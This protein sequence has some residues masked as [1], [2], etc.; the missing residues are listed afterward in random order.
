MRKRTYI[1][2]ALMIIGLLLIGIGIA[3]LI[4]LFSSHESAITPELTIASFEKEVKGELSS[5][6]NLFVDGCW[7]EGNKVRCNGTVYG[8]GEE[9]TISEAEVCMFI[10]ENDGNSVNV[11]VV[12]YG[13]ILFLPKETIDSD[14]MQIPTLGIDVYHFDFSLMCSYP[15]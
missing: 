5:H 1:V 15:M 3:Y 11:K 10:T 9:Y 4:G 7:V 8:G 2:V 13:G 12:V 6:L 14:N